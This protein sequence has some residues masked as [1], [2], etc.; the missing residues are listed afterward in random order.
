MSGRT[1]S[2]APEVSP[3]LTLRPVTVA[4]R[5]FLLRVY[6]G[7]REDTLVA[8]WSEEERSRFVEMQFEAQSSDYDRRFPDSDHSVL[9]VAGEPVGRMWV[10]RWP[11]QLRLLDIALLPEHRNQGI[12]TI[13]IRRLQEDAAVAG[14][15]LRHSVFKDNEAG[16]RFYERLGFEVVEDFEMYVL[17]EWTDR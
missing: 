5:D 2:L 8:P 7:T 3:E 16:L 1:G 10:G 13:A 14:L 11:D 9:L 12:G 15:P 4:D 6:E 17:M